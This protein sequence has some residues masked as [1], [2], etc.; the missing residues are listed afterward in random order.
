MKA[1]SILVVD[2]SRQDLLLFNCMLADFK[3]SG[4]PPVQCQ[5]AASG[6]QA[7]ELIDR[8]QYDLVV[9]DQQMPE[10]SGADV[11]RSL[12]SVLGP[13]RS[14]PKILAYSNCDLPEFRRKCIEQGADAFLAKYMDAGDFRQLLDALGL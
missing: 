1:L 14:R 7:L 12:P 13:D 5:D 6:P 11:M 10:M 4:G 3:R 9:L 8:N 2:D